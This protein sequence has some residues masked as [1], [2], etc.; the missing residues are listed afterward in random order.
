MDVSVT[1]AIKAK[2]DVTEALEAGERLVLSR[3]AE[4][5][6]SLTDLFYFTKYVLGYKDVGRFHQQLGKF[7]D[8]N[9]G[10]N[11]GIL[12]PRGAFQNHHGYDCRE[13]PN[14]PQRSRHHHP[15]AV[16]HRG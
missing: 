16:K 6:L 15:A 1:D 12:A 9:K 2:H 4:I 13:N 11:I 8:D 7:Y 14:D 5:Q 3:E 10:F